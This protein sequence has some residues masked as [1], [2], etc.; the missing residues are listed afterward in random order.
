MLMAQ[1]AVG[2]DAGWN[3]NERTARDFYEAALNRKD[4]E[5]AARYLTP[6]YV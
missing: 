3:Q 4:L 1:T 5:A 6:R 2:D